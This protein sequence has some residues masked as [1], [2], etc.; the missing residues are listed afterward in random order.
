MIPKRFKNETVYLNMINNGLSV[1]NNI[2]KASWD[3]ANIWEF[4]NYDE[5]LSNRLL[6]RH[7]W[8]EG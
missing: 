5:F 7:L 8:F 4:D 2:L 1:D 3:G 6:Q